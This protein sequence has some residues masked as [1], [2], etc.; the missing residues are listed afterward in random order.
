MVGIAT[1]TGRVPKGAS[2]GAISDAPEFEHVNWRKQPNMKTLYF[3][4]IILCVASAT[5]G[6]DG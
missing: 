3:W 6:Y 4:C 5:T 1:M 2:E